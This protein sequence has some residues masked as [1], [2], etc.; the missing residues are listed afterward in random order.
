M[1]VDLEPVSVFSRQELS[2]FLKLAVSVINLSLPGINGEFHIGYQSGTV[3][4]ILSR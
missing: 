3:S 2:I 1:L 4:L